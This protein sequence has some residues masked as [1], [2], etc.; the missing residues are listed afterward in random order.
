[1]L[2]HCS[3]CVALNRSFDA[4]PGTQKGRQ[5]QPEASASSAPKKQGIPASPSTMIERNQGC[6]GNRYARRTE[7][8]IAI[9]PRTC[10]VKPH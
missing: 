8:M 10:L 9:S 5:N 6:P 2:T 4:H 7:P 1:M 3:T